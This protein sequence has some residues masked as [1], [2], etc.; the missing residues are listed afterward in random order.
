MLHEMYNRK[1]M[2]KI[3]SIEIVSPFLSLVFTHSDMSSFNLSFHFSVSP[4]L[5]L[6]KPSDFTIH[7]NKSIYCKNSTCVFVRV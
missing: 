2:V 4:H 3:T 1:N 5:L 7:I 6:S